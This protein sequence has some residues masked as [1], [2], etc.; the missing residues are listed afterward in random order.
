VRASTLTT[1]CA[2]SFW[3]IA[4]RRLLCLQRTNLARA[5]AALAHP[6]SSESPVKAMATFTSVLAA[7]ISVGHWRPHIVSFLMSIAHE[8]RALTVPRDRWLAQLDAAAALA[9]VGAHRKR[10][11]VLS[12]LM[13]ALGRKGAPRALD[14]VQAAFAHN[15][16]NSVR[17]RCASEIS[18]TPRTP[19]PCAD[20]LV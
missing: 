18:L 7:G 12:E 17:G 20:G 13:H 6:L 10:H 4:C 1:Y 11:F 5:I 14:I 9:M 2:F 19:H 16:S 8:A 15:Y 3:Q